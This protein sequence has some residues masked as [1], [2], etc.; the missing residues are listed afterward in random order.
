MNNDKNEVMNQ[1]EENPE[2]FSD[3]VDS[4]QF[5]K[6]KKFIAYLLYFSRYL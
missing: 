3:S 5:R 4:I 2:F 1:E 6:E